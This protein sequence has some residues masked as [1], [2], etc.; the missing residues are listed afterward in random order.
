MMCMRFLLQIAKAKTVHIIYHKL[1]L[2]WRGGVY[3]SYATD[4]KGQAWK[5]LKNC[6]N[7]DMITGFMF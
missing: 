3:G 2:L 1:E 6:L 7:K 4:C 5:V